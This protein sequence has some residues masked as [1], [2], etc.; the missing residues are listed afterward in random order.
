MDTH[1]TIILPFLHTHRGC[2]IKHPLQFMFM[3]L[4]HTNPVFGWYLGDNPTNSGLTLLWSRPSKPW[5]KVGVGPRGMCQDYASVQPGYKAAIRP[6]VKYNVMS[7]FVCKDSILCLRAIICAL[8]PAHWE[9][10]IKLPL[11]LK[12]GWTLIT[13][14]IDH[15]SKVCD[16]QGHFFTC[17]TADTAACFPLSFQRSRS[18]V[19]S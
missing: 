3:P 15:S 8:H 11:H 4:F 16:Y 5:A 14:C 19:L 2:R 18:A 10:W 12:C 9:I 17:K 1:F 6:W 7:H 13:V